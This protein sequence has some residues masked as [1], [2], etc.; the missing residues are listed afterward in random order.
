[1]SKVP[2]SYKEGFEIT[3][4]VDNMICELLNSRSIATFSVASSS[5]RLTSCSNDA[6]K[7]F[8]ASGENGYC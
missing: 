3:L 8:M 5:K 7:M 2:S 4:G 1:M 6:V